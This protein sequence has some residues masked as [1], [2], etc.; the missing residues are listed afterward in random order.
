MTSR[1]SCDRHAREAVKK[2]LGLD[3]NFAKNS[4]SRHHNPKR[5]RG[6]EAG[7]SADLA[8]VSSYDQGQTVYRSDASAK[9][10]LSQNSCGIGFQ[11]VNSVMTG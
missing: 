8:Q 6:I 2:L 4:S 11:P 1:F 7:I 10:L 5:Q 3:R 9:Q